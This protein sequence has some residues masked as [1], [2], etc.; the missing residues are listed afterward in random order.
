MAVLEPDGQ[1]VLR[2][3]LTA[4][5]KLHVG[6]VSASLSSSPY[7][8]SNAAGNRLSSPFPR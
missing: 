5:G 3:G 7:F 2:S 1:V 6:G 4:I 8:A